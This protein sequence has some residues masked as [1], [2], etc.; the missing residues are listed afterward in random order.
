MAYTV[1]KSIT[2]SQAFIGT[3]NPTV[4]TGS[5]PALTTANTIVSLIENAPLTWPWN[6][7][8]N[9]AQTLSIGTQDYTVA[10]ADFAFL[11]KCTLSIS[12]GASIPTL[13]EMENVLN[14][15]PLA[16]T[17]QS[18]RPNS[19]AV[20]NYIPGTSVTFRF[21]PNP[22]QAY[23]ATF[24][25]QKAPFQFTATSQDWFTNAGIPY[26]FID[27]FNPLF[28]S[29][30]FQYSDD[31]GR[32]VQYRQRGMAALLAKA[33]G[34]TQMQKNEFLGLYLES[35]LQTIVAQM[36]AQ[37]AQQARGV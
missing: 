30:M 36:K 2:Y 11:E 10:I 37:Q 20:Q 25:Y 19:V 8:T 26:S 21:S 35:D 5:E 28:L 31:P 12:G 22:D 13:V 23:V 7:N 17:S 1:D 27:V 9:S 3:L 34:L 4:Y 18:G 14:T 33:D 16:K 24:I 29:E 32:A 15:K 6:R